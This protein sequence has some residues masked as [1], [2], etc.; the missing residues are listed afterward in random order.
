MLGD[1][2]TPQPAT[3]IICCYTMDRWGDLCS[4]VEEVRQQL[5]DGG[6]TI[7]CVDH[8]RELFERA[9]LTF[10]SAMVI[11]NKYAPGLSAARNSAIEHAT[12]EILV[13]LD[14]DAVP[15]P[16]WLATLVAPFTR[17]EVK[18][19]GG[20]AQPLWP[21]RRPAWFPVEF[22]WVV[23]CSYRGMPVRRAPIRNVMGCNMAIHRSVFDA[24]LTFE[25]TV[26]RT[27]TSVDGCEETELCIKLRR[28]WPDA[29]ILFEPGAT[30]RHRVPPQRCSWSY[31]ARRCY[32]EGRSKA[33]VSAF[34]GSADALRSEWAYTRR[35]LPT[36]FAHGL[37]DA[38]RGNPHGL[39]RSG[40]I[41]AGLGITSFGYMHG[42]YIR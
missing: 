18:A 27:A 35:V 21:H 39:G 17:A 13:F 42:R 6:E 14:D 38:A 8:N 4:A 23:G 9:T 11:E 3:V 33:R 2:V 10:R 15:G 40:A 28:T 36:G 41:I 7:I 5:G 22:D 24:G 32:A 20:A 30:V 25:T 12:G 16:G 26:G 19:V 31:F 29:Q 1:D 37:R 34:V